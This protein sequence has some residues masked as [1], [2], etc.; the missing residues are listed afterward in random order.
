MGHVLAGGW[1]AGQ[2]GL[3]T[4]LTLSSCCHSALKPMWQEESCG[5]T[6]L[7]PPPPWLSILL[8]PL[9]CGVLLGPPLPPARFLPAVALG[10]GHSSDTFTDDG[11]AWTS[12]WPH[13]HRGLT[14]GHRVTFCRQA[15]LGAS[16]HDPFVSS[17][18]LHKRA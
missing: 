10:E 14:S 9:L 11:T 4:R 6:S 15:W 1:R 12:W 13:S 5:S 8:G 16:E 2:Q 17:L 18:Q 3:G 7:H